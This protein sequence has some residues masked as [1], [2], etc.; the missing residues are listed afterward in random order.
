MGTNVKT[1]ERRFTAQARARV[2]LEDR[3]EGTPKIV[4]YAAVYYDGTPETEFELWKGVRERVMPGAFNRA[5]REDDVRGLFNH[6]ADNLLGRTSAETL[7]L[8]SDST[9]LR[10][11]IDPGDTTVARDVKELIRR[12]DLQGSSFSF[13]V[14]NERW[15]EEGD[16][17]IREVLG[18]E[19]FDVGPVTFPAYET[20]TTGLRSG[21]DVEW[22]ASYDAWK[23]TRQ[24][25]A[26]E[27]AR[28]AAAKRIG[29]RMA[30]IRSGEAT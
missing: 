9:G 21:R 5:L 7:R 22:R 11:E 4:G 20:T 6:A 23:A 30:Q 2:A 14:E 13:N 3:A 12:G 26:A 18:V 25:Q 1:P 16:L 29:V 15:H 8:A 27:S 10:Y 24:A 19:L 17:E 28:N